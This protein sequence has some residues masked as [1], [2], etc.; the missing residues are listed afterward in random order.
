MGDRFEVDTT[1]LIEGGSSLRVVAAEFA[2]AGARSTRAAD[3]VGHDDLADAIREFERGWDGR[4]QQMLEHIAALAE[5]CQGAGEEI[6]QLDRDF[7]AALLG[8]K[9]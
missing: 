8:E 2:D 6:E 7:A 1:A 4:R 3:A 9:S 5:Q